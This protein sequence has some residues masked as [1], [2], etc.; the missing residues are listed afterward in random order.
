MREQDISQ[1][2]TE[3]IFSRGKMLYDLG[4]VQD[5]QIMD[6]TEEESGF[7]AR[8]IGNSGRIM[9]VRATFA[10]SDERLLSAS[11]SCGVFQE[12]HE[13]CKH[14]VAAML[15]YAHVQQMIAKRKANPVEKISV[16]IPKGI[17]PKVLNQ[18]KEQQRLEKERQLAKENPPSRREWTSVSDGSV[19]ETREEVRTV[20]KRLMEESIFARPQP[21][22][23]KNPHPT[24]P[25]LYQILLQNGKKK[26][27]Y[28]LEKGIR[29]K[30]RLYPTITTYSPEELSV[31][32]KIGQDKPYVLSNLTE[33]CTNVEG[34]VYKRY[35][36]NLA[37]THQLSAF[38][39]QSR[40]MVQFL[41]QC[42]AEKDD[43]ERGNLFQGYYRNAKELG[44]EITLR[45][46][47]LDEFMELCLERGIEVLGLSEDVPVHYIIEQKRPLC[48]LYLVGKQHGAILRTLNYPL[49]VG[50][51]YYYLFRAGSI[52]RFPIE[53]S[54][55]LRKLHQY[56]NA[57]GAAGVFVS[58][59]EL[60][61]LCR[62]MLPSLREL[63]VV[64]ED[65]FRAEDYLPPEVSFELYI[66]LEDQNVLTCRAMAVYGEEKCNLYEGDSLM[67]NRDP[68]EETEAKTF[69]AQF[70]PGID[71]HRKLAL[72]AYDDEELYEFLTTGMDEL[73][74]FGEIYI[75]DALKRVQVLS[76]PRFQAGVSISGNLLELQLGSEDLTQDEIKEILQR[77]QRKKKFYRLKSGAFLRMEEEQTGKLIGMLD[78]IGVRAQ[79]LKQGGI[80]LPRYRALYLD[81]MR[82]EEGI[83]DFTR[84]AGFRALIRNMKSVEESEYEIP[85]SLKKTLRDYQKT[86]FRW[87]EMLH[88]N[89]FGGILADDMGLGKTLQVITFL[90]AEFEKETANHRSL[91]VCPASLIYNWEQE[92]AHFAPN[93]KTRLIVGSVAERSGRIKE[94]A[95]D[96]ILIT[97]YDL[98]KRDIQLY[99]E[100]DFFCEVI[101]EA[102][103]IKNQA[104]QAAKAVKGIRAGTRFAL[105]GTPIE[106]RLSELWS[107]FD[108]LMPGFLFRYQ[109]FRDELEVPIVEMEDEQA[110]ARLHRLISPFVLRRLK[111]DVLKDLPEKMEE[112]V[113]AN[114]EGEQRRLYQ[115]R[116]AAM[117]TS[118][119]SQSEEDVREQKIQILSELT[120]LREICCTPSL[121]YE[122]FR[123]EAAK[124]AVCMQ[125]LRGAIDGGHKVLI[126]SQF[127]SML[128]I[129]IKEASAEQIGYFLLTG[130]TPKEKRMEMVQAFQQ[131]EKDVFFISLKAGGTGLNLTAADI[132]IHFDPWW[133]IAAQNQATDRTHR[134]GQRHVVT[135]YQLI[136]KDTIEEKIVEMQRKKQALAEEVLGGE[137]LSGTAL[138]KEAL[139]ELLG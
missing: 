51:K 6:E 30:V 123:E 109:V 85:Q 4:N 12:N 129:L 101:D 115:A 126:F 59:E 99:E 130:D 124:V 105:T 18:Q 64:E 65:N 73:S 107:I 52:Y 139:L 40:K 125:L 79:D 45:G 90:Q 39:E 57:Q 78:D 100:L 89:G 87:L 37:F 135:V 54:M 56:L 92:I 7:Q 50:L 128:D 84:D 43:A 10:K 110:L 108:Y 111:K 2:T 97:S 53:E 86:G 98:L 106:N 20:Q 41:L 25:T 72:S 11:C 138:N 44:K 104:T 69:L 34:A 23:R 95:E 82:K 88:H 70:F 17:D 58:K 21:E 137:N 42:K 119:K 76:T 47:Q 26:Q 9:Q 15:R 120:H 112:I 61:L 32:F 60:P 68:E 132:V 127:A 66:D 16:D 28:Y 48:K 27:R 19:V 29:G 49:Y 74:Q 118:L 3:R 71:E 96:E 117:L 14:I 94:A 36:K 81:G 122:E 80:L 134:I 13:I 136:A 91:I 63:Y 24:D 46:K 83:S 67:K 116:A 103:F 8:V 38:E 1:M 131:G 33:F 5:M 35:G 75:S 77:Y 121:V 102:Q 133:N 113:Y 22:K 93:L 114:L 31:T 55:P 62:D